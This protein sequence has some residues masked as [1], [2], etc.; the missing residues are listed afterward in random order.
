MF[1]FSAAISACEKG[2]QW[3]RAAPLLHVMR[4]EGPP[5][6]VVSCRAA[7]SAC[8]K[9][10]QW[11]CAEPLFEKRGGEGEGDNGE[12]FSDYFTITITITVTAQECENLG[13]CNIVVG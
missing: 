5:H 9:S 1:G 4:R 6:N 7:I 8:E 3:Q 12:I 10:G 2:G 13:L 11:H